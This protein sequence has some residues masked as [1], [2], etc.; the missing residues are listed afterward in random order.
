MHQLNAKEDFMFMRLNTAFNRLKML[1]SYASIN[2]ISAIMIVEMSIMV[3]S[4][5]V[6]LRIN[7]NNIALIYEKIFGLNFLDLHFNIIENGLHRKI[8]DNVPRRM[9]ISP[10]K[11]DDKRSRFVICSAYDVGESFH[12]S[13]LEK[14]SKQNLHAIYISKDDYI[15]YNVLD[16]NSSANG[17]L[18]T[19]LNRKD[20]YDM[21]II[22]TPL[23]S[24]TKV[25]LSLLTLFKTFGKNH[26]NINKY[27]LNIDIDIDGIEV[28]YGLGVRTQG[29]QYN[30]IKTSKYK[31]KQLLNQSMNIF[32]EIILEQK[33]YS[34]L[35]QSFYNLYNENND[36]S[37]TTFLMQNAHSICNFSTIIYK[38]EYRTLELRNLSFLTH[39]TTTLSK[40]CLSVLIIS[41]INIDSVYSINV[42]H[43]VKIFNNYGS[44][45]IQTGDP[46]GVKSYTNIGLTGNG[47]TV[48]V[49]DTGLDRK[50][51][52]FV[53]SMNDNNNDI[54]Y[55][56]D[57]TIYNPKKDNSHRKVISY[58]AFADSEDGS[59]HGTHVCG[60]IAGSTPD[61]MEYSAYSGVAPGSKIAFLDIGKSDEDYLRFPGLYS[62]VFPVAKALGAVI[63]S[64][65]WGSHGSYC[66]SW[67]TDVDSFMEDNP[68]FL[69]LFAAGNSGPYGYSVAVPAMSKNAVSVGA[70]GTG[71][72][73]STSSSYHYIPS[74]SGRGP[75]SDGRYG[76]DVVAPG[77]YI[78]S[79]KA[80]QASEGSTCATAAMYGTSMS[81]PM[82]AGAAA[83]AVQYFNDKSFWVTVCRKAYSYCKS[84]QPSASLVKTV[85][86]HSGQDVQ[87]QGQ[88]GDGGYEW[89]GP[90]QGFGRVQLDTV[91]YHPSISSDYFDLF[92]DEFSL[93]SYQTRAY[94]ITST[95]STASVPIKVTISWIDPANSSSAAKQLL[96][97][98][99]LSAMDSNGRKYY[100][101]G[102]DTYDSLN[103]VEMIII[104][105]NS[106]SAGT[107]G[108]GTV[109]V[110]VS[111]GLL[112]SNS[113][114]SQ[115]VSIVITSRG[116][117][118]QIS[119][120]PSMQSISSPPSTDE[121][122]SNSQLYPRIPLFSF[123]FRCGQSVIDHFSK[124]SSLDDSPKMSMNV[125]NFKLLSKDLNPL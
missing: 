15:C 98:I 40:I 112:L 12:A 41:L 23:P 94:Q 49:A 92:V 9:M 52:F 109:V 89:P 8:F 6:P 70:T 30:D 85:L 117:V 42:L 43:P 73:S 74:W 97:D 119:P 84:F 45:I 113:E 122:E 88:G 28:E 68:D 103:N 31:L 44:S 39:G 64:N 99:D 24:I 55:V 34:N 105:S 121:F 82:V 66:N 13:L 101:N 123:L 48:G 17:V 75:A 124:S 4:Q 59:G 63:H 115:R 60:T 29:I 25:S 37:R 80:G 18:N 61:T 81:T 71:H 116:I 79:A 90:D 27:K 58:I 83:M 32:Y 54:S 33:E 57:S 2:F 111:A 118:Y 26:N 14:Y 76:V 10:E 46:I 11:E 120:T 114:R 50:S 110:H 91:L 107:S 19:Q 53:D 93:T 72:S 95:S 36:L 1:L 86:I 108:T 47:I 65:S 20:I 87:G 102:G 78:R 3:T 51:C 21:S 35:Y 67:C 16:N 62:Y 5:I 7:D 38:K 100:G 56:Q 22:W 96:H 104:D 69:I 77:S 106:V 125:R